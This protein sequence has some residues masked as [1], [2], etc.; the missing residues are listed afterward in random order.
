MV[1]PAV[2]RSGLPGDGQASAADSGAGQRLCRLAVLSVSATVA[3]CDENLESVRRV[4]PCGRS[5]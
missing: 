3:V 4:H 5:A 2:F 1:M